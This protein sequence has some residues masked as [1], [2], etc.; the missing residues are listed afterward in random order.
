MLE[1]FSVTHK[2][3]RV[4]EKLS[5][6]T[7]EDLEALWAGDRQKEPVSGK[8]LGEAL[9]AKLFKDGRPRSTTAITKDLEMVQLNLGP[10][11]KWTTMDILS[12]LLKRVPQPERVQ[13]SDALGNA[14]AKFPE[15]K[16]ENLRK[17]FEGSKLGQDFAPFMDR[18]FTA[19]EAP[20]K[21][22][23]EESVA[24]E[25]VTPPVAERVAVEGPAAPSPETVPSE[26]PEAPVAE[27]EQPWY[28]RLLE[29]AKNLIGAGDEEAVAP[30][31]PAEK[32]L[33]EEE[34]QSQQ[35]AELS[36]GQQFGKPADFAGMTPITNSFVNMRDRFGNL[37]HRAGDGKVYAL[38]K[39][40]GR[41]IHQWRRL[42]SMENPESINK[43]GLVDIS[44]H[45]EMARNRGGQLYYDNAGKAYISADG[46]TP[47]YISSVDVWRHKNP[48]K[49]QQY[50]ARRANRSAMRSNPQYIANLV[51]SYD[52]AGTP[53]P[54][55]LRKAFAGSPEA[56]A[57]YATEEHIR[58][59]AP[60]QRYDRSDIYAQAQQAIGQ[61]R[62]D[63]QPIV[64]GPQREVWLSGQAPQG[65]D[66]PGQEILQPSSTAKSLA[67]QAASPSSPIH[68]GPSKPTTPS[69]DS[70]GQA[71]T[72]SVLPSPP[73]EV[74][75]APQLPQQ[76]PVKTPINDPNEIYKKSAGLLEK[77]AAWSATVKGGIKSLQRSPFRRRR[78]GARSSALNSAMT[79]GGMPRPMGQP[80]NQGALFGRT[81]RPSSQYPVM[82]PRNQSNDY[83]RQQVER[84]YPMSPGGQMALD[85]DS[86][87]AKMYRSIGGIGSSGLFDPRQA[88]GRYVFQDRQKNIWG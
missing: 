54:S 67:R 86:W 25:P 65:T 17:F 33:T 77:C 64:G 27:P 39:D 11:G 5:A 14:L 20:S 83:R 84:R 38:T 6:Y 18:I 55:W 9:A 63:M 23:P 1:R 79:V 13:L 71:P 28:S 72:P 78:G 34:R 46:N 21:E 7:A 42:A 60:G 48:Q 57:E 40:P 22:V 36:G 52:A 80:A 26:E 19:P 81:H 66:M 8:E 12:D 47:E 4:M 62:G 87:Q 32:P 82:Y 85:P 56:Q 76:G 88:K 35:I 43:M 70:A 53:R 16:R 45:Q 59:M 73:P 74:I 2:C 10:A 29:G 3:A 61:G 49:A 31:K 44:A 15:R 68:G 37:Y 75:G 58:T 50:D 41:G 24:P 51:R 69:I 30:A